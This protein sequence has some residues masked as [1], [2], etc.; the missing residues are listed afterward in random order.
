MSQAQPQTQPQPE[1]PVDP[2]QKYKDFKWQNPEQF[3][4]GPID[5]ETRKCRDCICC[6][7]FI[8][9]FALC[10]VVAGFG[11]KEGKPSQLFYFY[12]EDGNA[13]G[14]D[15]GFEDYKYLYF[16]SVLDG[17]KKFDTDKM[18]D[19]VCVKECPKKLTEFEEPAGSGKKYVKLLCHPTEK[20]KDCAIPSE[21]FYESKAFIEKI[22]FPKSD[23]EIE[24][25]KNTQ[26][27]I[28]IYDPETGETFKKVI[29]NADTTYASGDT[30]HER[31]FIAQD[32][33]DGSKD[34]KESSARLINLSYF[35]QLFT[36]WINDL[37]VTRW[38]I[39]ASVGWSFFLAMFYFVFLRCCAGFITFMIILL[40]QAGLI[41]LAVYFNIL[42]K[43]EE[44][45]EAESDTTDYAFFWVFTA[46]AAIWFLFILIMCNR[47]RLAIAIT[48]V[49]SKY[50]NKTCCI[51]FVPFLFFIILV[52]W[53]AYWIVLLVYLYTAGEFDKSSIK[54]FASFK[55]D[56]KL[57]YG[58]WYHIVMLFYITAVIEA[59]SQ[60]VYASSACIWYFT[61][62]K[63]TENHPIA[64]SFYRGFRYHFGSIVFG[65]T[66]IAIIRF[67]MFFVEYV[68]KQMEKTTGKSKGKCFKCIFCVIECCLGCCNKIMEFI[69]KHAYIQ[70]A[71]KGDN[72]CTAAWEGFGLIIRNLGRFSVLA[73]I[74][75]MFSLIGTLFITVGS[76]IIGY[77]L[78]TQ[79][80]YFSKDLNSCVLPEV[81]F[82]L[83]GFI[84]GRVSMSI[85]SVSSDALIHS[86]LLDE[87]LN[88][89][90]PK[91]FPDLQK[92]MSDER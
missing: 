49:T 40:V 46:L 22:C 58:F 64:K 83:I 67:L 84:M 3:K 34:P 41:V 57:E 68:K 1:K 32:A 14:H 81:A 24:Y 38:A 87:E 5:D 27:L 73:L 91:A 52:I 79:V 6:I 36:L 28:E 44:E 54:I 66:I 33:I 30:N 72:F 59:Y 29:N 69:N 23:D 86:F 80:D 21:N 20:N 55:M 35:T 53:L 92:F 39:L 15:P 74:G 63:G 13:C 37:Y 48:E 25:D 71:L 19:A 70:I 76:C 45:K 26:Q 43:K 82:G 12:D 31:P 2:Y 65:A 4:N 62:E 9:L 8:V 51:V 42:S 47:I 60:F 61:F 50:I 78:I 18:L 56:E 7:I 88:K 10:I 90:Q 17:L 16:T 75:G 11:F 77:F 85:F 89:G